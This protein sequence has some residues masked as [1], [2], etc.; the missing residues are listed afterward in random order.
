MKTSAICIIL[1]AITADAIPAS[2]GVMF[3]DNTFNLSN[4]SPS[5]TYTSD[6]SAS[7]VYTSLA[8]T[9]QFTS[10]FTVPGNPPSYTVAQGLANVTFTYDPL[11]QGAIVG[12]DASVLKNHITNFAAAGLTNIVHPTIEQD[13]VFYVATIPGATF[14]GPNEPNGTGFLL[15]SHDDLQASAFRSYDFTTGTLGMAHPNFSGDPLTL[16]IAEISTIAIAQTGHG[17]NQYRDLSFDVLQTPEPT[18]LATLTAALVFF[19]MLCCRRVTRT[20]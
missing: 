15:F 14:N 1:L 7:I 16:G 5:P 18:S 10:T 12:I 6:P 4:Y 2:A 9:L 20:V 19:S 17:I 8:G 3:T 11:T 13:G